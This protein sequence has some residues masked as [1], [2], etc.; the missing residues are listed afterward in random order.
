[1]EQTIQLNKFFY[2]K[3]LINQAVKD[4]ESICDIKIIDNDQRFIVTLELKQP[5]NLKEVT[6]EFC[7]YILALI[8]NA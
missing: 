4:Y 5:G 2:P 7:N 3:E 6:G 8:K 1:M